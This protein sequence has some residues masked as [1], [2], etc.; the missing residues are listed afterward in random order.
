M[1][2]LAPIHRPS[3][4]HLGADTR[5]LR[6]A[7]TAEDESAIDRVLVALYEVI[8]F[9]EGG[10]PDWDRMRRLFSE[11]ARITR[12]TPEGIDHLDFDGFRDMARELREIGV[13]TSFYEFEV[14]RRLDVMGATAHALSAYET[15]TRP[16]AKERLSSGVNSI[17]LVRERGEWRVLSLFWQE[18]LGLVGVGG[19]H[20]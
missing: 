5:P 11:R 4:P 3:G 17:Q 10:E 9:D 8:C 1:S 18:D 2:P 19:H 12:V 7:S 16:Q 15:R 13:Y 6:V 20:V 14:G